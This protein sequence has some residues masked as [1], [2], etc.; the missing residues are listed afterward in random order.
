VGSSHY[1]A[2][3]DPPPSVVIRGRLEGRANKWQYGRKMVGEHQRIN[4]SYRGRRIGLLSHL[5]GFNCEFQTFSAFI[6]LLLLSLICLYNSRAAISALFVFLSCY[7]L[8]FTFIVLFL[9]ERNR[10]EIEIYFPLVFIFVPLLL[11]NSW[12]WS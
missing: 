5:T 1:S 8:L 9:L 10:M 4:G 12:T 3:S 6:I 7:I 2:S 11:L